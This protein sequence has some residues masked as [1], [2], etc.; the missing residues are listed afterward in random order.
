MVQLIDL[1]LPLI[2]ILLY[3]WHL[4]VFA[5]LIFLFDLR[6]DAV[7]CLVPS[8]RFRLVLTPNALV[9]MLSLAT[10]PIS[11]ARQF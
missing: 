1:A 11:Q 6:N 5:Y 9:N 4:V 10:R 8:Y 3:K 7:I 2:T